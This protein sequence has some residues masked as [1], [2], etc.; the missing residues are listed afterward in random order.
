M[1]L[2]LHLHILSTT[3]IWRLYCDLHFFFV[4]RLYPKSVFRR[5]FGMWTIL[6][7]HFTNFVAKGVFCLMSLSTI[8]RQKRYYTAFVTQYQRLNILSYS[9][10][11]R[12]FSRFS[13]FKKEDSKNISCSHFTE[14]KRNGSL[15]TMSNSSN[16]IKNYIIRLFAAN[17]ENGALNKPPLN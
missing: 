12:I 10:H 14:L 13:N 16:N 7:P 1:F 17:L 3:S 6:I 2:G 9:R 15:G 8:L 5:S 11:F 4:N